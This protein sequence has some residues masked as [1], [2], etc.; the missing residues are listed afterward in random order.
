MNAGYQA[1][2][3]AA[4]VTLPAAGNENGA[5]AVAKPAY[6]RPVANVGF[7]DEAARTAGID[8][9]DVQPG[10]MIGD[11]QGRTV[12]SRTLHYQPDAAD[13][14][15]PARPVAD[16]PFAHGRASQ[17]EQEGAGRHALQQMQYDSQQMQCNHAAAAAVAKGN[18]TMSA[19]IRLV[20]R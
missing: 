1:L 14:K 20:R 15:Q 13:G 10:N 8:G 16:A 4:H 19:G 7:G 18:S 9:E 11:N 12:R 5:G 2:K 3:D 6:Q 17:R